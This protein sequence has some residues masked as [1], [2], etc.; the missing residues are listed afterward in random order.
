MQGTKCI[1]M[2][3]CGIQRISLSCTLTDI[4]FHNTSYYLVAVLGFSVTVF[5]SSFIVSNNV[6]EDPKRARI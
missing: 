3:V 5:L 2:D 6:D 4:F 1:N